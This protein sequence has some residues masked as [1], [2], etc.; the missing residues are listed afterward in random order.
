MS[1]WHI[2]SRSSALRACLPRYCK[3]HLSRFYNIT[4]VLV[5]IW[6]YLF[7]IL[8]FKE[9]YTLS[10]CV[11]HIS[12]KHGIKVSCVLMNIMFLSSSTLL[13]L[14]SA[15]EERTDSISFIVNITHAGMLYFKRPKHKT[16][17]NERFIKWYLMLRQFFYQRL[18][19]TYW[20]RVIHT[21]SIWCDIW[22]GPLFS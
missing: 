8:S 18:G 2:T 14:T 6:K 21:N 9:E 12:I 10:I 1:L 7:N 13:F 16:F 17:A 22:I 3:S 15:L 19:N 5:Q 11:R 4:T 20:F